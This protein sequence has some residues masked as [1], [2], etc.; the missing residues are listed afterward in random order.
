MRLGIN[1]FNIARTKRKTLGVSWYG[2]IQEAL[3][4]DA[5]RVILWFKKIC[6]FAYMIV[7]RAVW[8]LIVI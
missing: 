4:N 5:L 8:F 1:E 3:R 6:P 7:L 2:L